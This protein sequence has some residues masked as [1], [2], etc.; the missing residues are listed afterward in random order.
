[1]KRVAF[2]LTA[3]LIPALLTA[4][5]G[6]K[7]KPQVYDLFKNTVQ[8]PDGLRISKVEVSNKE[9]KAFLMG[10]IEEN[11]ADLIPLY[12]PDVTV[13]TNETLFNNPYMDYYFSHPAFDNYPVV[14]VSY[15][16]AVAYCEWKTRHFGEMPSAKKSKDKVNYR[17]RLPSEEE[18]MAAAEMGSSSRDFWP[19]GY[20]YPRN[21]KGDFLFN[22]KLGKGDFAGYIGKDAHY[23]DYEGYMVTAPVQTFYA[24]KLGLY[25]V[26]GN[27]AEMVAEKGIAKGGSW[28]HLAED[29]KI[30]AIL[31]YEAPESWIGFRFVVE[32]AD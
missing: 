2:L 19:G 21:H 29:C 7:V 24:D 23:K 32:R 5:P 16:A 11:K 15:E 1:M 14:G 31:R 3:L 25:N 13:W 28:Y 27:A 20:V 8:T 18:W 4:G 17:F 10:L 26:A 12:A 9:Y 22:H 30:N 6:R